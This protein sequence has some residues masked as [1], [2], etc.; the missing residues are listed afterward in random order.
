[1]CNQDSATQSS[2]TA[3]DDSAVVH[4]P[5]DTI[6]RQLLVRG[7]PLAKDEGACVPVRRRVPFNDSCWAGRG[8]AHLSTARRCAHGSRRLGTTNGGQRTAMVDTPIHEVTQAG[9]CERVPLTTT[10]RALLW[11]NV[12]VTRRDTGTAGCGGYD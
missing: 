6:A 10:E 3:Y 1:M 5:T 7:V 11:L 9:P 4:A 12:E 2:H 8:H